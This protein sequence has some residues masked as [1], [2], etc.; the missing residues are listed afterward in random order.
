MEFSFK[1]VIVAIL[2]IVVAFILIMM[3]SNFATGGQGAFENI[4]SWIGAPTKG[5]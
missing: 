5:P 2:V 4:I 3:S 1:T